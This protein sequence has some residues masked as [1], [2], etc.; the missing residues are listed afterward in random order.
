MH[1]ISGIECHWQDRWFPEKIETE[2]IVEIPANSKIL[3]VCV[4]VS[5][6]FFLVFFEDTGEKNKEKIK[7]TYVNYDEPI[8]EDIGEF[9]CVVERRKVHYYVFIKRNY[10][11]ATA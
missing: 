4:S 7:V 5:D 11:D 8:I 3:E 6:R 2:S 9:F 10:T 1:R